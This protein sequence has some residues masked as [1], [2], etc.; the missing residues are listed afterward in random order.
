M[1]PPPTRIKPS[2]FQSFNRNSKIR[3]AGQVREEAGPCMD[4][5]VLVPDHTCTEEAPWRPTGS[6]VKGCSTHSP[7]Q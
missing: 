7:P 6:H 5:R 4:R 3:T 1:P 2:E